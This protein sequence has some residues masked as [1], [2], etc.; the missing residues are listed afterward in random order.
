MSKVKM[1]K[2]MLR[3]PGEAPIVRFVPLRE[4]E[5]WRYFMTNHHGKIVEGEE[6]S[7]WVDAETYAARP[8]EQARPLEDVVRV[9]L[10][11]WDARLQ[12]AKLVQRFF[13][14]DEY[15]TIKDVFLSHFPDSVS[16]DGRPISRKRV[17]ETRGYYINPR[18]PSSQNLT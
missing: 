2:C 9:D 14:L 12:T 1:V 7:A 17:S 3:S 16:P 6:I 5:L 18:L 10:Q 4:F 13:P 11:H 15:E 8:P